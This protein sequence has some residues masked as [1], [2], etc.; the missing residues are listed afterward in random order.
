M[1]VESALLRTESA[2]QIST[3]HR[4]ELP[5]PVGALNKSVAHF[6]RPSGPDLLAR[7]E[8]YLR[9]KDARIEA[10][11]WPYSRSIATAPRAHAVVRNERGE[12]SEG[13]NFGSQDYL[14]LASHPAVIEAGVR[15]LRDFGP[16][17]ASSPLLQGDTSLSLQLEQLLGDLLHMEHVVLFPTGWAAGFGTIIGLVRPDDHILMDRLSHACL[18]Q[19]AHAA[20]QNVRKHEHLDLA[21]IE[22]HLREIRSGDA[23]NGIL[24]VSEGLFSMDSDS[25]DLQKLQ[26]LCREYSATL[27]V[28]VAHDLGAQ[29]PDGA[30][31]IGLQG[32][33]GQIDLVIG[34]FSKTFASNGGFLATGSRAVK[35]FVK[36]FGGP[37]IFSN[38]VSPVQSATV[39]EA[40]KIVRSTEGARLRADLHR[41]VLSLRAEFAARGV[42]CLGEPSAIVP[43]PIGNEKVGRVASS[44]LFDR[45]VFANLVEFPAVAVGS[46]RFRMQCMASHTEDDVRTAARGVMESIEEA[47]RVLFGGGPS[48]AIVGQPKTGIA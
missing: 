25:P 44:I 4:V 43:V 32:M 16:H 42:C 39:A 35:H 28:D 38:A 31:Q 6:A 24:V 13:I 8:S 14:S 41:V 20:T 46:S 27:L 12:I 48:F 47:H 19:G 29:G 30:G 11:L 5:A 2:S 21:E 1:S 34:A 22:E 10:D 33:L 3:D 17:S 23:K 15:A 40:L 9:W 36:A 45:G 26:R 18:Q 37:H 7:T